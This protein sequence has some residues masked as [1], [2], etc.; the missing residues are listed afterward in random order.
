MCIRD[1]FL[2]DHPRYIAYAAFMQ[3]LVEK[4][5]KAIEDDADRR[6]DRE[7]KTRLNEA[8]A[9]VTEVFN[10]FN[11]HEKRLMLQTTERVRLK[12]HQD[13]AN[14]VDAAHTVLDIARKG[15]ERPRTD[16]T[17]AEQPR[18]VEMIPVMYG[19]GRLRFRGQSFQV[20]VEPRG[21]G[22]PECV[23]VREESLVIVNEQHPSY[24]DAERNGWTEG[25][26]FRAVATRFACEESHTAQ[27]AY[28]LL[29]KM[30]RFAAQHAKRK[31]SGIILDDGDLAAAV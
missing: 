26:V 27:E 13:D 25:V 5:A 8:V 21:E 1:S 16:T 23:I 6:R 29:D 7:R 30:T 15:G 14:G 12:G 20:R 24:E 19:A 18:D 4:H 3:A 17:R 28:E 22:A 31:R 10:A 2:T 9:N 11:E